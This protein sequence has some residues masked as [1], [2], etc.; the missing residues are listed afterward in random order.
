[1]GLRSKAEI[2]ELVK[3]TNEAVWL[4]RF[5]SEGKHQ[6]TLTKPFYLGA[7]E[8]TQAQYQQV[9]GVNPSHHSANG[10]GK[11]EVAGLDTDRYPVEIVSWQDA[12]D[13][14]IK[15]SQQEGLQPYYRR[16]G[17]EVTILGG[18]GYRLPT[19]AE[20]EFACRA[21][22]QTRW[23]FGDNEQVLP[24]YGWFISNSSGRTH[25]VGELRRNPFGLYDMH[26]NVWEW[27]QDWYGANG[28]E[29]TVTDPIGS[30][31]G[32]SRQSR[33]GSF[34]FRAHYARSAC[35]SSILPD[36]RFDIS[37]FRVARTGS[38]S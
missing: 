23:F 27:R 29:K 38:G 6:V 26:G 28:S 19:K 31:Q 5:R 8:V 18:N 36:R 20:W 25:A 30:T 22:T 9:M 37:G 16:A 21:G 4:A 32:T 13:F 17:N 7:Y 11:I 3:T 1:M 34:N 24:Q 2:D 12:I 35:R 15:L 10:G 33:G 14:C